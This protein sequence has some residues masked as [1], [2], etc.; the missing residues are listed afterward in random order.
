MSRRHGLLVH[1][2]FIGLSALFATRF[3]SLRHPGSHAM[4]NGDPATMAWTLQWMS[5][6][7]VH[8]PLHLYAGNVFFPYPHAV[9]L[10]DP[11]V[12]LALLNI[13]VRLVTSNPWVGYN[14]LIFAAYY[15]SCVWGA[16]LTRAVTGSNIAAVW[17]GL[18]WGFLFFRVHHIGHLQLLSFQ[19][20]PAVVVA[21]LRFWQRPGVRAALLVVLLF[22]A[23][24]LVSWYLAVILATVIAVVALCRPVSETLRP[25]L[26]GQYLLMIA[27]TGAIVLP[28]ALPYRAGFA[29]SSLAERYSLVDTAGDAVRV[30]DYLTP[31]AATLPGRLVAGNSYTIWGENTLYVGFV[32]LTLA[33][34]AIASAARPRAVIDRRWVVTGAT[35]VAVGYVLAL[36]FVSPSL[37]IRL[38]LHYLARIVPVIGGLRAPQRFSLVVYMGVLILSGLGLAHAIGTWPLRRQI[39]ATAVLCAAFLVEVFPVTLPIAPTEVYA[40]SAPDRFVAQYQ[41]TRTA[42]VVLLHLPIFYFYEAYPVSEATYMVD[43]TAHWGRILNGFSGGVPAGFMERMRVLNTLPAPAAL[44]LLV[45]LGVDVIAVHGSAGH[46]GNPLFDFFSQQDW[47]SVVSLPGDEFVVLIDRRRAPAFEAHD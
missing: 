5:R 32:P 22:S 16:A 24:A 28:F 2:L 1:A 43:S 46:R 3:F 7:L 45:D 36:G 29:D 4:M 10:S 14:L 15:L 17:G 40:V 13:P 8:D 9:T 12:T 37:G 33:L 38:P 35:L 18:F 25:H 20:I 31:P 11:I 19:A 44:R 34:M 30:R 41:R 6:A 39:A 47:T 21:L 42:P 26:A 23:Q 27:V